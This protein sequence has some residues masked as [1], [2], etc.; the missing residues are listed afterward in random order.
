MR[1]KNMLLRHGFLG[2]ML[3]MDLAEMKEKAHSSE[4]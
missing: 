4:G 2:Q 3:S 1:T